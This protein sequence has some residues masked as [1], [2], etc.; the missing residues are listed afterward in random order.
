VVVVKVSVVPLQRVVG[1]MELMLMPGVMSERTIIL[2]ES[3]AWLRVTQG[4][5]EIMVTLTT[6]PLARL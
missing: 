3:F 2:M 4:N 1:G 5:E 6:S